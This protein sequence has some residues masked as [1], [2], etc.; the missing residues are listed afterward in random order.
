MS[1][2]AIPTTYLGLVDQYG[3]VVTSDSVSKLEFLVDELQDGAQFETQVSGVTRFF[4]LYGVY[5]VSGLEMIA[6]PDSS[7]SKS[8]ES[9]KVHHCSS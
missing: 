2:G 7:Q 3:Q 4:P 1:G 6:D 5:N 9:R 8:Q